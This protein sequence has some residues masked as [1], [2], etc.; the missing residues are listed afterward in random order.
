MGPKSPIFPIAVPKFQGR[1]VDGDKVWKIF[2]NFLGTRVG[3][4]LSVLG[5]YPR[6]SQ[7]QF[8]GNFGVRDKLNFE[9]F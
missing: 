8:W 9:D 7:K 3:S 4:I 5:F 2:G 6:N 1:G